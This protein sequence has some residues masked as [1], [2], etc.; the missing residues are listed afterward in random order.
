MHDEVIRYFIDGEMVD[1]NIVE[2]KQRL[3]DF[4]ESQMRDDGVVPSLDLDPQFT[5]DYN[6]SKET[7]NFS[8]SVYGVWIGE[9]ESWQTSGVTSGKTISRHTPKVRSKES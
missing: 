1:G 8:L 5:L 9:R 7:Y 3:V 6:A 4:L 2:Q